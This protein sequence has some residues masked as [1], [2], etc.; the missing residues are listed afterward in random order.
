MAQISNSS[1]MAL[2]L[3]RTPGLARDLDNLE[4]VLDL[5]MAQGHSEVVKV[6]MDPETSGT[7]SAINRAADQAWR[8]HF[9]YAH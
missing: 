9:R 5:L 2:L 8:N 4:E 3:T 6:L 1:A 7:N